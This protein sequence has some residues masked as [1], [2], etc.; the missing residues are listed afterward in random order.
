MSAKI[1]SPRRRLT[2]IH[3][4]AS[5]AGVSIGTV[6]KALRGQGRLRD[7]TRE[8]VRAAAERLGFRPNDLA[9]S[10][11]RRKS[12]TIGLLSNDSYGRFT[13]PLL[14]GIQQA[15]ADAGVSVFLCNAFDD[16]E[17]ERQLVDS[18]LAKRVDGII[19]TSRRTD[20]RPA[21]DLGN[22]GVPLLYAF[23]RI[24][25]PGALCLVPDDHGGARLGVEHLVAGG[26]RHFAHVTG[27]ERFESV[28]LRR[29]AYEEVLREHGLACRQPCTLL[30][31][32]SEAW[33]RE[34]ANR[35]CDGGHEVDAIFC[36][37]DLIA[38]GVIDALRERG[39]GVPD[40]VAVVGFDNWDVVALAT[41]PPLTTVDMNMRALGSAAGTSLLSLIDGGVAAGTQ[42]I[43]CSLVCAS[44]AAATGAGRHWKRG[45]R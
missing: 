10:L 24:N 39:V 30:G 26:R 34:A 8:R 21:I 5:A 43:P 22:A 17:R 15:L 11:H 2:T 45:A 37:S 44:P 27:P 25:E 12:F 33:G 38:R 6:S 13:I 35:L 41:R 42:R 32:W 14:E 1:A 36:G 31:E 9:H 20:P 18:L 29:A 19:V 4:V 28:R 16:P 40:D 3:D 23:T 7:E